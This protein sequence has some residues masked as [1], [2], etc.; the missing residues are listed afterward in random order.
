MLVCNATN[1]DILCDAYGDDDDN[2]PGHEIGLSTVE[3]EG[4]GTGWH[5]TPLDV[6]PEDFD[7]D[8]PF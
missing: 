3:H 1:N 7:D 4:F 5:I 8:I 2:W 6:E